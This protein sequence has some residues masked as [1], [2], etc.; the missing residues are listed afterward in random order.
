MCLFFILLL[1]KYNKQ[2]VFYVNQRRQLNEKIIYLSLKNGLLNIN[3]INNI[4][5]IY[6]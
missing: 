6:S 3:V 2:N 4:N 1:T 5:Y